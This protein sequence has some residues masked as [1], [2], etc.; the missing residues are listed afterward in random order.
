MSKF[1]RTPSDHSLS[2]PSDEAMFRGNLDPEYLIRLQIN[3]CYI[4]LSSGDDILFGNSVMALLGGLPSNKRKEI[5]DRRE[6]YV[7]M[8]EEYEY[9]SPNG[10]RLG[11]PEAPVY[12]NLPT[13]DN[14]DPHLKQIKT[15]IKLV[16]KKNEAG[17]EY[18]EEIEEKIETYGEPVLIS[19]ILKKNEH[20]DYYK[21]FILCQ[22]KLEEAN[23]SWRVEQ[24]TEEL[25]RIP[26]K[27]KDPPPTPT[28]ALG[29]EIG[30]IE[31]EENENE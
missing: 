2:I 7:E 30:Q 12:R 20:T 21:L 8:V 18:T 29:I 11:S 3:R 25:G 27:K 14:Y 17:E 16:P 5:E 15:V 26:D 9:K 13:D 22:E 6:D 19:P 1:G 24:I 4:A 31:E 10:W 28:L 23:L